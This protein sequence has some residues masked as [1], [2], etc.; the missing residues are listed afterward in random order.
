MAKDHHRNNQRSIIQ[1]SLRSCQRML[2]HFAEDPSI[3]LGLVMLYWLFD[4]IQFLAFPLIMEPLYMWYKNSVM[5]LVMSILAP[6]MFLPM[7]KEASTVDALPTSADS[8]YF[9][10]VTFLIILWGSFLWGAYYHIQP[11]VSALDSALAGKPINSTSNNRTISGIDHER[12]SESDSGMLS[13]NTD[14]VV[15]NDNLMIPYWFLRFIRSI[16]F[17]GLH[18]LF[19]PITTTLISPFYCPARSLWPTA[20]HDYTCYDSGHLGFF[21]T[22]IIILP[23]WI[24]WNLII[25]T[26]IINRVPDLTGKRNI[27]CAS[28]GRIFAG[29]IIIK[30]FLSIIYIFSPQLN[31]WLYSILVLLC[32]LFYIG[33]YWQYLPYFHQ[34][35]NQL[36]LAIGCAFTMIAASL[37]LAHIIGDPYNY[38]GVTA[39]LVLFIP[40][41]YVGYA[42][43]SLRF[44]SFA[45]H[46]E[47]FSPF[48]VELRMRYLLSELIH[49]LGNANDAVVAL[50]RSRAEGLYSE[51]QMKAS[52]GKLVQDVQEEEDMSLLRQK[53]VTG[54][55]TSS[56]DTIDTLYK[57]AISVFATS[58]ILQLFYAHFLG[59]YRH[60]EHLERV[61]MT[62]SE[63]R[64][65]QLSFD[66]HFFVEQRR[67]EIRTSAL[68]IGIQA[69][70]IER[71]MQFERLQE[72]SQ[73]QVAD[74]RNLVLNF[75]TELSNKHPDLL[76][77][78]QVGTTINQMIADTRETFKEL[79]NL[80]PQSSSVMRS[81]ADFLLELANDPSRAT[82]LLDDAEQLEDERSKAHGFFSDGDLVFGSIVHEFDLSSE[83][84]AWCKVSTDPT[85]LGVI[86][87]VNPAMI[88]LFG[89]NRREMLGRDMSLLVPEPIASIHP[90]IVQR[91]QSTGKERVVNQNRVLLALHRNG[92]IFPTKINIRPTAE[93]F[94]AVFEEIPSNLA[95]LFFFGA[96]QDWKVTAA[97]KTSLSAFH[98]NV[99]QMKNGTVSM[100]QYSSDI[101]TL[102]APLVGNNEQSEITLGG[103]RMN[104]R[105]QI[106]PIAF[107]SS[108]VYILRYRI[109]SYSGSKTKVSSHDTD[110]DDG[111]DEMDVGSEIVE[112]DS[113]SNSEKSG[114]GNT[115]KTKEGTS[116]TKRKTNPSENLEVTTHTAVTRVPFSTSSISGKKLNS[117]MP[118]H[119]PIG[120]DDDINLCPVVGN[121]KQNTISIKNTP[122]LPGQTEISPHPAQMTPSF[123]PTTVKLKSGESINEISHIL[124]DPQDNKIKDNTGNNRNN[125]TNNVTNGHDPQ[126]PSIPRTNSIL[127]G[128]GPKRDSRLLHVNFTKSELQNINLASPSNNLTD[129]T[130]KSNPVNDNS[131]LPNATN[132]NQQ[133]SGSIVDSTKSKNDGGSFLV[134]TEYNNDTIHSED[135]TDTDPDSGRMKTRN[136]R[137]SYKRLNNSK[138]G[139]TIISKGSSSTESIV[140]D[141]LRKGVTASGNKLERSLKTLR[142]AI[143]LV[144]LVIAGLN[145]ISLIITSVLFSDLKRNLGIVAMNGDR[146]LQMNRAIG[147]IQSLVLSAENKFTIPESTE[148]I[149][150]R[151]G[152]SV[153]KLETLHRELYL[154]INGALDEEITLYTEPVIKIYDLIPGTYINRTTWKA[155]ERQV[156]LANA[157]LEII[158]KI[159]LV[160]SL[161]KS[162]LTLDRGAVW[163]ILHNGLTELR[164]AVNQSVMLADERTRGHVE[165]IELA[166]LIVMIIAEGILGIIIL[167]IM[168]PAVNSVSVTKQ[169]IFNTFLEVPVNIIRA[170]RNRVQKKLESIIRSENEEDHGIDIETSGLDDEDAGDIDL[171][172]LEKLNNGAGTPQK[173]VSGNASVSSSDSSLNR[174]LQAYHAKMQHTL[175]GVTEHTEDD[176]ED[177][178]K[179][180]YC[181]CTCCKKRNKTEKS[182]SVPTIVNNIKKRRRRHFRNTRT[183]QLM[184]LFM[185]ILP[186]LCYV[187]YFAAVY[188]W[189]Y[190]ASTD[191]L[192]I[193]AEILWSKQAQV[194]LGL[195]YIYLRDGIGYCDPNYAS[196]ALNLT[197]NSDSNLEYLQNGL[198]YGANKMSLRP[199]IHLSNDIYNLAMVN[200]CVATNDDSYNMSSCESTFYYGI[201]GKGFMQGFR[202]FL[203]LSREVVQSTRTSI[204]NDPTLTTLCN[205]S[206][207]LNS[208]T[209]DYLDQMRWRYMKEGLSEFTRLRLELS[210]HIFDNFLVANIAITICTIIALQFFFTLLYKRMI[211][212]MDKEIKN[213]R[214][215]LLLFPDEVSK[216][217][218][219]I[220]NVGKELLLDTASVSSG[221]TL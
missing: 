185:M 179:C 85:K 68:A 63:T 164:E 46:G 48:T 145:L 172:G 13:S 55:V 110:A 180:C 36:Q 162:N 109:I 3:H 151:L 101:S 17:L 138:T 106:S 90:R 219:A 58:A 220:V 161:P 15:A 11:P 8:L 62:L 16:T 129:T 134:T 42:I 94:I 143:I 98:F 140:S 49:Q 14:T 80:A 155:S 86:V 92:Y 77:V 193:K 214:L 137:G 192:N 133:V 105:L 120:L 217:V 5:R 31:P 160:Q 122:T 147:Y 175:A 104:A 141:L 26:C 73:I 95:F 218:P 139:G 199:G 32:G 66:I 67:K 52:S 197:M 102:L 47:L 1:E 64:A 87:D 100:K 206:Q 96:E 113:N 108:P 150:K 116:N 33:I 115:N 7:G 210:N 125:E 112:H 136:N 167:G 156:G 57:D 27:L 91:Y 154:S 200:G 119:P 216:Q 56:L 165:N 71:R 132:S 142:R 117:P 114:F 61:Y 149:Q 35:I 19:I 190:S 83:S 176:F 173:N 201:F 189:R 44:R 215:L 82:E 159:R 188:Q 170:L 34:W 97:C 126:T 9:A 123:V 41:L 10:T 84:L 88:K 78:Q 198:M 191:V 2:F 59:V 212:S 209:L 65:D 174:A 196:T 43:G 54:L 24:S 203:H 166:N 131:I 6:I 111:A 40:A 202:E 4:F 18:A 152:I 75:W 72:L 45:Q 53:D 29:I 169:K 79:L 148:Y 208:D 93:Q 124:F 183:S 182:S 28:H 50:S 207:S 181:L 177:E 184:V 178:K 195:L 211:Q 37:V 221:S 118:T 103:I 22:S 76:R 60:N 144:F 70:T 153:D 107:V 163:F 186:L 39:G 30:T 205:P 204:I 194:Y 23:L 127:R 89:Y 213:V 187:V 12:S 168:I 74:V 128:M 121:G 21:I 69:M 146:A 130:I 135:N 38:A 20:F 158:S 157:V 99:S 81:Y 51:T 25:A 171:D